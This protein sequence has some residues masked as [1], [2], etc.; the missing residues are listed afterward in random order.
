MNCLRSFTLS[1]SNTRTYVTPSAV[2]WGA[3]GNYHWQVTQ[4]GL[5]TFNIQGFKN[6]DI[7]GIS[8]VSNVQTFGPTSKAIVEDYSY[9][10]TLNGQLPLIGG[11]IDLV[12]F[13]SISDTFT[14]FA[15]GK[16]TNEIKFESPIKSVTS[17]NVNEFR[18]QGNN[19]EAIN[20]INLQNDIQFIFY[21]NFEG[22]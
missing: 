3:L 11:N 6:I 21:Y 13:W 8:M 12:N 1:I 4:Q 17:I 5:S 19:A 22:E 7:Y 2:T 9:L 15:I 14:R 16:Y 10:L 20:S 18:A